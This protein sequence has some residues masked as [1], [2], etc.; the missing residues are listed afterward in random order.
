MVDLLA[1]QPFLRSHCPESVVA[2]SE[3]LNLVPV[4]GVQ[5]GMSNSIVSRMEQGVIGDSHGPVNVGPGWV[6]QL[7]IGEGRLE[8]SVAG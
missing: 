6:R 3:R 4:D 2:P 1:V 5:D 7:S 8:V